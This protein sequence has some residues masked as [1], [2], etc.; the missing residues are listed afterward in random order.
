MFYCTL[1]CKKKIDLIVSKEILGM[2]YLKRKKIELYMWNAPQISFIWSL[3]N[4]SKA[5][6]CIVLI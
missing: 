3:L 2:G 4:E 1:I 5:K 6:F